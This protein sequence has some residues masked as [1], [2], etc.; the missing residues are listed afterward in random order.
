M[1]TVILITNKFQ[2]KQECT[3]PFPI[4]PNKKQPFKKTGII[5]I[6]TT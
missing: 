2:A 3:G 6:P 5:I 1:T 4:K